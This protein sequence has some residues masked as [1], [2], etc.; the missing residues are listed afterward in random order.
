MP[1][2]TQPALRT[3]PSRVLSRGPLPAWYV[4]AH[5]R[6]P[7][8]R[9]LVVDP[10]AA[11]RLPLAV[12]TLVMSWP[13]VSSRTPQHVCHLLRQT[14]VTSWPPKCFAWNASALSVGSCRWPLNLLHLP[15]T[16]RVLS[17]CPSSLH[18]LNPHSHACLWLI[19]LPQH[20]RYSLSQ[21]LVT[22][23]HLS[24]SARHASALFGSCTSPFNCL[25]TVMSRGAD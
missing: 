23:G 19:G 7:L 22:F 18:I 12:A 11:T 25:S 3:A 4:A 20:L 14:L 1:F 5:P 17:R 24:V 8:A 21:T 13:R 9:L 6:S 16:L 10:F 15:L 2:T